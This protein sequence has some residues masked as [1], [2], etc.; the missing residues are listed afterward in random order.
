MMLPQSG[1]GGASSSGLK[2]NIGRAGSETAAPTDEGPLVPR[3]MVVATG[4]IIRP[5]VVIDAIARPGEHGHVRARPEHGVSKGRRQLS[6]RGRWIHVDQ[7]QSE[8]CAE[9]VREQSPSV[10]A[11]IIQW[12]GAT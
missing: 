12:I 6:I 2:A 11:A 5:G 3:P 9:R 8:P 1:Q 10:G 4:E 7:L